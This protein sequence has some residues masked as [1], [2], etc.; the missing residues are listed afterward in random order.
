MKILLTGSSGYIGRQLA[1]RLKQENHQVIGLD[2]DFHASAQLDEFIQCDLLE[3]NRYAERLAGIDMICHLAAAKGDWGISE[4]EYFRDNVEATRALLSAARQA[5]IRRWVFYSTVSVLGPS[6]SPLDEAAPHR[7]M[8]PYGASKAVCEEMLRQF[9][10]ESAGAR[11]VTIRPS[12]VFGPDNPWN[13][14]VFRLIEAIY[15]N[16]FAMIGRGNSVKTTS[17]IANL[18][19]AHMFLM[20]RWFADGQKRYDVFH[21]VDDPAETTAWLVD[22]I[23]TL[24]G[25]RPSRWRIPLW[26]ASPLALTGDAAAALTGIDL[27]ITS[28]RVR[29]FCTATNFSSEKIRHLGFIQPISNEDAVVTTVNWYVNTYLNERA[30]SSASV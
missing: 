25:R 2:R 10:N 30:A 18:V 12:V 17:Y 3:P 14:N 15:R 19:D 1:V 13:T 21:C 9:A 16:R 4:E 26:M 7:P 6:D 20:D 27:P 23:R 11:V 24:L 8:N 28:A 22:R 5:D 29:K